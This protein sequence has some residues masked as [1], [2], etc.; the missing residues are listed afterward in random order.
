MLPAALSENEE[1]LIEEGAVIKYNEKKKPEFLEKHK[2]Y[3][4]SPRREKQ[5]MK[6]YRTA[7]NDH[8]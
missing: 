2:S 8:K 7:S 6:R 4:L 3:Y 5:D 1:A